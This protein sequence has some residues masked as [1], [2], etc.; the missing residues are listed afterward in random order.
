MLEQALIE[1]VQR[2][3]LNPIEQ[4]TAFQRLI[5]ECNLTQDE[6]AQKIG[7]ERTTVTNIIRL[8]KLP[9]SIQDSVQKGEISTGHARA[10]LAVDDAAV[11]NQI[12]KKIS[13]R[14]NNL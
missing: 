9:K 1:K 14:R 4:A 11:Q 6:V 10:L 7:K 12:C 13:P 5:D 8:L 3:R 2:E